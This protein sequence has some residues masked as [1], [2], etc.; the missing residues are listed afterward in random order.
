MKYHVKLG[1]VDETSDD[2]E[3]QSNYWSNERLWCATDTVIDAVREEVGRY[4]DL[5]AGRHA[6]F[7][8]T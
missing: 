7:L 6:P 1:V 4:I 2:K 8:P 3:R 5:G